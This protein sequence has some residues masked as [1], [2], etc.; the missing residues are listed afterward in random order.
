MSR[1]TELLN[2]IEQWVYQYKAEECHKIDMAPGLTIEQIQSYLEEKPYIL[3][4]EIVELYQWHNGKGYGS[5]FPSPEGFYDEQEFYS[6][7]IG[8]GIGEDW[9]QEYC[10]G[11]H[12]LGMFSHEGNYC[13]TVLPEIPQ[14][15]APIYFSSDE[16]DFATAAPEYPS[17]TAFLEKKILR[18]KFVWKID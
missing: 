5:L 2:Q 18:L 14:E 16:P 8:L 1:L 7:P 10:P 6:L 3:P 9:E 12:L 15:F 17:L 11:T 13:W 4:T